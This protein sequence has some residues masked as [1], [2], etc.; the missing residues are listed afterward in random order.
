MRATLPVVVPLL[1]C[2]CTPDEGKPAGHDTAAAETPL[3]DDTATVD[4][5]TDD[6]ATDSGAP[7]DTGPG[8]DTGDTADT[9][10]EIAVP[11]PIPS[12]EAALLQIERSAR[13]ETDL[14]M[15]ETTTDLTGD[16]IPDLLL[17]G[18]DY[19]GA[20]VA[21]IDATRTGRISVDDSD[22]IVTRAS[23]GRIGRTV[24]GMPDLTGD[25][26]PDLFVAG[27]RDFGEGFFVP[28]PLAGPLD[29][30]VDGWAYHSALGDQY[31]EGLGGHD[32]TG[33]G[34]A[35]L[36]LVARNVREAGA[37]VYLIEGPVSGPMSPGSDP[38]YMDSRSS[39]EPDFSAV[40]DLNGDGIADLAM[41]RNDLG[42]AWGIVQLAVGPFPDG[43]TE[44][45]VSTE[46]FGNLG[47]SNFGSI[48]RGVGDLN[49]DGLDDV[50]AGA[51]QMELDGPGDPVGAVVIASGGLEGLVYVSDLPRVYGPIAHSDTGRS[52][53]SA[54][55]RDGDGLA[56]FIVGSPLYGVPEDGLARS[57][58]L[59]LVHGPASGVSYLADIS[60]PTLGATNESLGQGIASV[61]DVDG[62][63]LPNIYVDG[64]DSRYWAHPE[65]T[66]WLLGAW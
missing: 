5:A 55:D 4:T 56:D 43:F 61:G 16:G 34:L 24:V 31:I 53:A 8:D 14:Y 41:G 21:V 44:D 1:V 17:G 51:P 40:G 57:G 59:W 36:L 52:V 45:D 39:R 10:E 29:V 54:G 60:T 12:V 58:A 49:G 25:G 3:D 11:G 22:A 38:I 9:G 32:W 18:G 62:D 47:E 2:A 13:D 46:L 27:H 64:G 28:G 42:S 26:H 48:V 63:G 15:T 50:V 35:D 23:V 7:D 30:E 33:D 65:L 19:P 20:R 6:T 66:G 37:G